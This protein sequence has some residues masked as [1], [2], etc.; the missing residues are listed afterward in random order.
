MKQ[1][2][3]MTSQDAANLMMAKLS[4]E[5]AL[6]RAALLE[7]RPTPLAPFTLDECH[8]I[9][10]IIRKALDPRYIRPGDEKYTGA[11][12]GRTEA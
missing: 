2:D 9:G 11:E 10:R 1:R 8:E 4:R 3:S 6:E 12:H 7:H 5:T